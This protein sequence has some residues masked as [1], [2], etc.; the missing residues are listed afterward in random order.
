MNA[1]L[2]AD[3][4]AEQLVRIVVQVAPAPT[5]TTP[6]MERPVI[7]AVGVEGS[8]PQMVTGTLADL[9]GLI[10]SAWHQVTP[11]ATTAETTTSQV[12]A[13]ATVPATSTE[14]LPATPPADAT[15]A[16]LNLF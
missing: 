8:P 3:P 10:E 2:L 5:A 16:I 7:V 14:P 12:V 4:L 15:S 13:H 11:P 1:F 6:R 9:A